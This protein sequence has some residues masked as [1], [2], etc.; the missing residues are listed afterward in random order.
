MASKSI[1]WDELLLT[2]D[3][4]KK[5]IEVSFKK[6]DGDGF[7]LSYGDPPGTPPVTEGPD[8]EPDKDVDPDGE[9]EDEDDPYESNDPI[10]PEEP[11]IECEEGNQCEAL[12]DYTELDDANY[13]RSNA[14]FL[15]EGYAEAPDGYFNFY[16]NSAQVP[17]GNTRGSNVFELRNQSGNVIFDGNADS[18]LPTMGGLKSDIQYIDD[19]QTDPIIKWTTAASPTNVTDSDKYIL[20]FVLSERRRWVGLDP[21]CA[22]S[23]FCAGNYREVIQTDKVGVTGGVL[24]EM[25][26]VPNPASVNNNEK[27]VG[28]GAAA[29]GAEMEWSTWTSIFLTRPYIGDIPLDEIFAWDSGSYPDIEIDHSPVRFAYAHNGLFQGHEYVAR[30][31]N[32]GSS[33]KVKPNGDVWYKG[34]A[35]AGGF[36]WFLSRIGGFDSFMDPFQREMDGWFTCHEEGYATAA[37]KATN[38]SGDFGSYDNGVTLLYQTFATWYY[39]G[40]QI[41]PRFLTSQF[42]RPQA[43]TPPTGIEHDP[44]VP[45]HEY[46]E[47]QAEQRP[48]YGSVNKYS[49]VSGY[50]FP[51]EFSSN[52]LASYVT[53]P[54]SFDSRWDAGFTNAIGSYRLTEQTNQSS[55]SRVDIGGYDLPCL[56]Y[57]EHNAEGAGFFNTAAFKNLIKAHPTAVITPDYCERIPT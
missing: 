21:A 19:V 30:T 51:L 14:L 28:E 49:R 25:A 41:T 40:K 1:D 18:S 13:T 31:Y 46:M 26:F 34:S 57:V 50:D 11:P 47:R 29:D 37:R 48:S 10:D 32:V 27:W 39:N 54:I 43:N 5:E 56:A 15:R 8:G 24:P 9:W 6:I 35:G 38:E 2:N 36:E 22:G 4:K 16:G 23:Y 33:L 53:K 3:P 44:L 45:I 17:A 42:N 52:V 12:W 20:N 55:F 7:L